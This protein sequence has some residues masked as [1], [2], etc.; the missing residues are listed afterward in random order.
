MSAIGNIS[1]F[2]IYLPSLQYFI[3][4]PVLGVGEFNAESDSQVPS[5]SELRVWQ[6]ALVVIMSQ[7][8]LRGQRR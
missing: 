7:Q 5:V 4:S 3:F 1:L 8:M 6:S 2:I